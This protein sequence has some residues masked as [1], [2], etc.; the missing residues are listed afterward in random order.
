VFGVHAI[1]GIVGALLTGVFALKSIGGVESS[2]SN[3]AFGVA[4]TVVYSGLM[5]AVILFIV[6]LLTGLRVKPEQE[7]EGL[8]LELHGE[9]VL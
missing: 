1:G 7:R 2:L 9:H 8:D 3:Q 5:T 4:V 6:R